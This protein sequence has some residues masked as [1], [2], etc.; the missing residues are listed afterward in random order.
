MILTTMQDQ[1]PAY[2][3]FVGW[4][5]AQPTICTTVH[6]LMVILVLHEILH[7]SHPVEAHQ[8]RASVEGN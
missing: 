5:K 2:I 6:V 3:A 7:W 4:A 1:G 8:A